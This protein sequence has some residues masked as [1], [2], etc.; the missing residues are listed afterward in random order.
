M[1]VG[2][3]VSAPHDITADPVALAIAKG[4]RWQELLDNGTYPTV[5]ALAKAVKQD[6]AYVARTIRLTLLAPDIIEAVMAG[7]CPPAL[8]LKRLTREFPVV[9]EDQRRA[10]GVATSAVTRDTRKGRYT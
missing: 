8:T 10:W 4:F 3:A 6:T 1:D 7:Q 9:W 5:R 2:S